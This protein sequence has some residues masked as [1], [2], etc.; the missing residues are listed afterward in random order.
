MSYKMELATECGQSR[1]PITGHAH[2]SRLRPYHGDSSSA[3]DVILGENVV[4]CIVANSNANSNVMLCARLFEDLDE[5]RRAHSH[6]IYGA[7]NNFF[8]L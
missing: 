7:P 4:R 3:S 6:S 8:T 2:S 5:K 1:P